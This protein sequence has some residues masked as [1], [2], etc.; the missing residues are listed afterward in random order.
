M[1]ST[2]LITIIPHCGME[3]KRKVNLRSQFMNVLNAIISKM[4]PNF[5][6]NPQLK[7]GTAIQ[8]III[9]KTNLQSLELQKADY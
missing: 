4:M 5:L 6:Q 3:K 2:T 9:K 8:F 7:N 1:T